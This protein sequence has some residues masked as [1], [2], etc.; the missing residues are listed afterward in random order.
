MEDVTEARP[1][2]PTRVLMDYNDELF[3]RSNSKKVGARPTWES[4]GPLLEATT[5]KGWVG[6]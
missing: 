1:G 2:A 3:V 4:A 6:K 5:S